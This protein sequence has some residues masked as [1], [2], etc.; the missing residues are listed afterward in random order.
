M[1]K[2]LISVIIPTLNEELFLP[3]LLGSIYEAKPKNIEIIIV[4]GNSTDKT[5]EKAE[6]FMGKLPIALYTTPKRNVSL[7]RNMGARH[8]RGIYLLFLDADA[9]LYPDFFRRL[10]EFLK[11]HDPQVLFPWYES[12][13]PDWDVKA[14][15]KVLNYLT[16]IANT[17][18]GVHVPGC[19]LLIKKQLF[20]ELKGFN[21]Y[22]YYG[23]DQDLVERAIKSGASLMLARQVKVYF[24]SR[25]T[26]RVGKLKHTLLYLKGWLYHFTRGQVKMDNYEMGGHLYSSSE[27]FKHK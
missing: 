27:F 20:R 10:E 24:S 8:A 21:E 17:L 5:R 4:D 22:K 11:E 13:V 7:Q 12:D 6:E 18:G 9:K 2:V 1:N 26:R 25:R 19:L 15:M 14:W 16:V 3:V 23:E